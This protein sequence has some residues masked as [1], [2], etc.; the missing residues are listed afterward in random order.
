MMNICLSAAARGL[1]ATALVALTP[2]PAA[3]QAREVTVRIAP[4]PLG[5]AVTRFIA[6]T[7]RSV[8]YPS[9]LVAGKRSRGVR[10]TF[11]AD[12]ALSLLL[13]GTGIGYRRTSAGAYALVA[14]S[15]A[16][17]PPRP[18][19]EPSPKPAPVP[20]PDIVV[21]GSRLGSGSFDAPTPVTSLDQGQLR[22]R[23]PDNI[24]DAI[25]QLPQ[26]RGSVV[27]NAIPSTSADLGTNGQNLVNMRNL[28]ATRTLVLLDGRRLPKTN[29]LG[30]TDLNILP[31]VLVKRID[32]VTGGAS[33]SYG[34]EAVAGVVN[35]ILDT[36]FTG[37]RANLNSGVTSY[38]DNGSIH[39]SI[40]AGRHFADGRARLI[41]SAEHVG[42]GPVGYSNRPNGRAWF[43]R[44]TGAYV[45]PDAGPPRLRVVP[46]LRHPDASVGGLITSGSL[47]GLQF[48]PGGT[49]IPF[50]SGT[51]P[52]GQGT[53]GGDG[54]RV[55][56]QTTPRSSR[57]SLFAHGE[58]DVAT[59]QTLYAEAAYGRSYSYNVSFPQY[60]YLASGQFTI[61]RDNAFLPA[62]VV[63][64]FA[65]NP[66]LDSF[67]VGRFSE[68]MPPLTNIGDTRYATIGAGAK[69]R[70][71]AHWAYDA[72]ATW[73]RVQQNL[74]RIAT[75]NRNLYA[76]ADAVVDA[77][78]RIVCRSNLAGGDPS[79]VPMNIFGPGAVSALAG[80]YVTGRNEGH[81]TFGQTALALN[82]R[83]DLG[84]KLALPAG[85]I[86][87]ALGLGYRSERVRRDVDAL[88]ASIVDCSTVRGCPA[89]MNTPGFYGG[90]LS[91][92]PSPL[93][94][95][96]I[97]TEAYVEAGIPLLRDQR[98][99]RALSVT[100][101]G[102]ATRYNLSGD[103]YSWKV[104]ASWRVD[105]DLRLRLTS[106]QD[107]RAPNPLELFGGGATSTS[108]SVLP[109]TSA[110]Y[111]GPTYT[112]V[113]RRFS[114]LGNPDLRPERGR[115]ET[116][117][118]VYA[119]SW[120]S[121]LQV[122]ID[123]YRIRITRAID[124]PSNNQIIDGCYAGD[125]DYC[126]LLALDNGRTPVTA[127]GQI[128]PGAVGFTIRATPS[129]IA[130][131]GTSGVDA[132]VAYARAVG[133]GQ[134]TVRL[135][136]N[137]LLTATNSSLPPG[138]A[139]LVG[140]LEQ[141]Q[142]WPRWTGQLS[143]QYDSDTLGLFVQ[144]RLIS[145]GKRN[146]N[147]VEGVDIASNRVPMIGY[148]D[149]TLRYRMAARSGGRGE[150]FLGVR[151]LFDR[152]PPSTAVALF[153]SAPITN[154]TLYDVLGRRFSAGWRQQW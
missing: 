118:G 16:L 148:T 40:A 18:V 57:T 54:G 135:M 73:S 133:S 127:I 60:Q 99:A 66:A 71:S 139:R 56:A 3:A 78:G 83:G 115:T 39:A 146:A 8:L 77:T 46:D 30:S 55:T 64:M 130:S 68:D 2:A 50:D 76:A 26:V 93:A 42:E 14:R 53:S 119:P 23:A 20:A 88:S 4:S 100:L 47:R 31:Q 69:G 61:F 122:A 58:Y 109:A 81:T 95:R 86:A 72:S 32:V 51:T 116:V 25:F 89:A 80:D 11:S 144:Q 124:T 1:S 21:T 15:P 62:P 85:P 79:C 94:G 154:F 142:S 145:A 91:Y 70:L 132:D 101:A 12:E 104:G 17:P 98:F 22:N 13:D 24:A 65:A 90:Y 120:A 102:R 45:N 82:L 110:V 6:Q 49:L 152:A 141:N 117:G 10:G 147:F 150:V 29:I 74:D 143:A 111:S 113:N 106:S 105:S 37:L 9:A 126:G 153:T 121:G 41:A 137:Y 112:V 108:L 7:G 128:T 33:A 125:R 63:A 131:L 59:G 114:G 149:V 38:G 34:S 75:I 151:N 84:T 92:N 87:V 136:G 19:A 97:A 27:S 140:A 35:L 123:Y 134:L 103:T 43:D 28:G 138:N 67:T 52:M 107:I 44:A 5:E 96:V 36:G 129:N 48:G